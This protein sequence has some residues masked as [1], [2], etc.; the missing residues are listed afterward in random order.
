MLRRTLFA[1]LAL[2]LVLFVAAC[3][4]EGTGPEDTTFVATM[5]GQNE[6]PPVT[7]DAIG[8]ATFTVNGST[9]RYTIDVEDITGVTGAHIHPG[10]PGENGPVAVP[11]Y[12]NPDGTDTVNGTLVESFFT[13]DDII[14]ANADISLDS[15]LVLM[16]SDSAYVNVHTLANPAGEIRG[17]VRV[18]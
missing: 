18:Q 14:R 12:Q 17:Q 7:T 6:V 3:E 2:V 13:G 11:L 1:P 5:E 8:T 15:L 4:D 16:R 10:A 9:V